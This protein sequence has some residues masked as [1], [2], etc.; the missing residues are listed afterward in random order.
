VHALCKEFARARSAGADV[1][2]ESF[3]RAGPR[4]QRLIGGAHRGWLGTSGRRSGQQPAHADRVASPRGAHRCYGRAACGTSGMDTHPTRPP[5][6]QEAEKR[7]SRP[8]YPFSSEQEGRGDRRPAPW[9]EDSEP[10]S[11]FLSFSAPKSPRDACFSVNATEQQRACGSR[12]L[13]SSRSSDEQ[14]CRSADVSYGAVHAALFRY[15]R[16]LG[17]RWYSEKRLRS[18]WACSEVRHALRDP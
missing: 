5:M 13:A 3:A 14:P 11:H 7:T 8:G 16:G 17:T 6:E 15:G 12:C 18:R 9:L 2:I 10:A 4:R 1:D